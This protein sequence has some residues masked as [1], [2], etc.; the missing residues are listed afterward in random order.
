MIL[1]YNLVGENIESEL[2][3][4]NGLLSITKLVTDIKSQQI[5]H[6]R[7]DNRMKTAKMDIKANQ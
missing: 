7:R 4:G 2:V 1:H 5:K 6:Q 3:G